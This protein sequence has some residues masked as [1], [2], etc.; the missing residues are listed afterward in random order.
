VS[1]RAVGVVR[2]RWR[3]S[4]LLAL[5]SVAGI[6]GFTWPLFTEPKGSENLAHAADAPWLFVL[7]LPLLLAVLLSELADG[8]LDAKAVAVLGVLVACGAAL[9]TP[10]TGVTGF[11]GVF[12][13]L[14]PGGRVF[15]RGFGFVQ[16]ALTM[17]ASALITGGVGPWLPY[18]ML[19][20]AWV[21]FG[22]GCLPRAKGRAEVALLAVYGAVSGL[23][24][25]LV[26][27]MWFWPFATSPGN[28]LHFVAGAGLAENLR[29]FWGFHVASALGFDLPRAAGN[30][31]LVL[32]AATP[33]LAALRRA[34]RRASFGAP[35]RF[36]TPAP[37]AAEI[38]SPA[39]HPVR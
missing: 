1:E 35:V 25:G 37:A 24:Y 14:L 7:V 21:G 17:F 6:V 19:C 38:A 4:V 22:A 9:R 13:L 31:A 10:A 36:V 28:E 16:G 23:V 34:A 39:P 11:T 20:C 12:F 33:V 18:Q 8:A 2:L 27:D 30:V 15:G 3:S 5:T 26:M 32:L 29:R